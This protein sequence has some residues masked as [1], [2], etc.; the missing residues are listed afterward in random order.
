MRLLIYC[1]WECDIIK[2]LRL[3]LGILSKISFIIPFSSTILLLELY[4]EDTLAKIKGLFIVAVFVIT[5]TTTTN[6]KS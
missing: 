6:N 2:S 5:T 1:Y 4:V 3:D